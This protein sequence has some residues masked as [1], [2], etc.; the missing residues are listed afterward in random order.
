MG[1]QMEEL[2]K[3][4]EK[5]DKINEKIARLLDERLG[6]V[7]KI[8]EI[9]KEHKL[10]IIDKN[11]EEIIFK[12]L[13][14]LNFKNARFNDIEKIFEKII[15]ISRMVQEC[16]YKI[17]FLGPRGTFSDQAA[18]SYFSPKCEFIPLNSFFQYKLARF[19]I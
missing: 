5:I 17:A 16:S 11:R 15:D 1:I 10:P 3:E 19:L 14:I 2:N 13:S 4:R 18:L 9:K 6:I 8:N 12:K 7:K